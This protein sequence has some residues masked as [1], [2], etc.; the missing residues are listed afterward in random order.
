MLSQSQVSHLNNASQFVI[1]NDLQS[2]RDALDPSTGDTLHL[3]E[4]T[5]INLQ[6]QISIVPRNIAFTKFKISGKLPALQVNI[7]DTKYKALMRLIDVCIPH[8]EE[9]SQAPVISLPPAK[10]VPGGFQLPPLFS[11]GES[12]YNVEEDGGGDEDRFFEAEDGSGQVC[13]YNLFGNEA[14]MLFSFLSCVNTYSSWASR[15]IV[16]ERRF[17]RRTSTAMTEL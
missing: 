2:C 16:C 6:L 5:N 14:L 7:S 1:G 11:Q 4:R 15:W 13:F 8:F 3:L 17:R 9:D 12:E 10:N